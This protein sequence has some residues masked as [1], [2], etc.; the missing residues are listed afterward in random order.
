MKTR[1]ID[2]YDDFKRQGRPYLPRLDGK[3]L[4]VPN[5]AVNDHQTGYKCKTRLIIETLVFCN[6]GGFAALY[7]TVVSCQG[8][9]FRWLY[10]H[11]GKRVTW[12]KLPFTF[13][14]SV[15]KA[16]VRYLR[17]YPGIVSVKAP[18]TNW[19]KFRQYIRD[20]T[21]WRF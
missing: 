4:L 18:T 7:S 16:Y 8:W 11:E 19:K 3:L 6:R 1:T 15:I 20:T 13:Q 12:K 2:T 14:L 10:W 5:I 17:R 21:E 9:R